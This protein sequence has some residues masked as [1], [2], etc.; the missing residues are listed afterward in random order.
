MRTHD[1]RM[2][3][4]ILLHYRRRDQLRI[5]TTVVPYRRH[6]DA[7]ESVSLDSNAH[8]NAELDA[9][10]RV[11]VAPNQFVN[12]FKIVFHYFMFLTRIR[13]DPHGRTVSN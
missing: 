8:D 1:T 9:M 4:S 5:S 12:M 13:I 6:L 2:S 11:R 10:N 3:D 7:N